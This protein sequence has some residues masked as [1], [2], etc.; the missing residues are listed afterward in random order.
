MEPIGIP[1]LYKMAVLTL[2]ISSAE[3]WGMPLFL[4]SDL[5]YTNA[6]ATRSRGMTR[7]ELLDMEREAKTKYGW[8]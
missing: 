4:L 1:E 5:L 6:G 3:F 7:K 8:V 2:K